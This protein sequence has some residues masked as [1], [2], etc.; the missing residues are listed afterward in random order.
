MPNY[1]VIEDYNSY[2]GIK[3]KFAA[4]NSDGTLEKCKG[5]EYNVEKKCS[6]QGLCKLAEQD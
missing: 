5:C 3:T 6:K 1:D 4:P 2:H